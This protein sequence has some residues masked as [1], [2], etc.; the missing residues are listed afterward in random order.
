MRRLTGKITLTLTCAFAL[1]PRSIA[2][3]VT[4]PSVQSVPNPEHKRLFVLSDI[5]ADPDDTQSLVR[6]LLY[7][8]EIDLEGLVATTSVH[9]KNRVAPESMRAVIAQYAKVRANLALHD[10]AYPSAPVLRSL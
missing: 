1:V 9:Q 3:E 8:N 2:G 10:R 5:E 4:Q 7:S 6:L